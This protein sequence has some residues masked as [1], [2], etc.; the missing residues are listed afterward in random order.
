MS[1]IKI[2]RHTIFFSIYSY[3][4]K[5]F[6]HATCRFC[7]DFQSTYYDDT[8]ASVLHTATP[9]EPCF[10]FHMEEEDE[11]PFPSTSLSGTTKIIPLSSVIPNPTTFTETTVNT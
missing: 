8:L 1:Y 10:L 3:L 2:V 5:A 7:T 6:L 4:C 11:A 9:T